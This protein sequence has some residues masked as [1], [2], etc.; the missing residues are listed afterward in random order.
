MSTFVPKYTRTRKMYMVRDAGIV[1]EGLWSATPEG[2]LQQMEAYAR[3]YDVDWK[4]RERVE[5]VV[6]EINQRAFIGAHML[7]PEERHALALGESD[8]IDTLPD[9]F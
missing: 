9:D 5:I 8:Q 1:Q 3:Y 2:L 4:R 7:T 6:F